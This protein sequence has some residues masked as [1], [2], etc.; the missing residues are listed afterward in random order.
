M[1]HTYQEEYTIPFDLSDVNG[2][3]KLPTFLSKLLEVSGYHS[4]ALGR[5]DL[6]VRDRYGCAWIVT[7][8]ELFIEA[9]P[10][11]NEKVIIQTEAVAYNKLI[12]H[13][14]FKVLD[15][16]GRL[17]IR[18]ESYFAL[19]HFENRKIMPVPDELIAPYQSEK[20][21]KIVRGAK[22]TNLENAEKQDYRVRY[23]DIDLN[24]HVNNSK[25]LEW[26]YDTLGYDFLSCHFPR[27][28]HLKYN[29]EVSPG[30]AISSEYCW[31]G[32]VSHHQIT[33]DGQIN[34]QAIIEWEKI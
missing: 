4:A 24:G 1:G 16:A 5:S 23:F 18:V 31:D 15:Q 33:S 12:C 25:Y 20:V 8:Y 28:I 13:R 10:T 9:L 22:Y 26:M 17:L 14:Q 32:L 2:H 27:H 7:D 3:L 34:A 6:Y 29:R 21:K 11:F 30:G 19:M